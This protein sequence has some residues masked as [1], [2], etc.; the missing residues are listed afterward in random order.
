MQIVNLEVA[1]RTEF[2]KSNTKR[3]KAQGFIPA[4]IYGE[5]MIPVNIIIERAKLEA[6]YRKTGKNT[7]I[8]LLIKEEKQTSEETVLTHIT[9]IDPLS[10]K[11]IHIDFQKVNMKK[12]IHT[13]IPIR[14]IGE[15]IGVKRGGILIHNLDQLDITCLPT[16]IPKY[17][18]INIEELTIG[19]SIRAS[20]LKLDEEVEL[21]T[22]AEEV[23]V[24]I[25]APKV[26]EV[27][28]ATEE[29]AATEEG[30]GEAVAEATETD[31]SKKTETTEA[32]GK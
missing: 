26:E 6:I 15:A 8:K 32:K 14:C 11:Y 4:V 2:G 31:E 20:E 3:I 13:T 16:N 30:A 19:D 12:K 29:E 17:V 27:E 28:E 22:V 23:V 1:K 25:E 10:R 21:E 7:L 24:A 9:D 18:E 5:K